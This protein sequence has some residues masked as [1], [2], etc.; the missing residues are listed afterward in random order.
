MFVERSKE[1]RKAFATSIEESIQNDFK[2]ACAK[3]GLQMNNVLEIFMRAYSDGRFKV[4]LE[5]E[6]EI[7]DKK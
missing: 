3:N 5:Y 2:S 7:E 6:S 4:E 1:L